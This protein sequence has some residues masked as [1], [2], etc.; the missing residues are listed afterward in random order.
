MV[1]RLRNDILNEPLLIL[2]GQ[3]TVLCIDLLKVVLLSWQGLVS[4]PR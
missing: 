2:C 3:Y 1:V 4:I